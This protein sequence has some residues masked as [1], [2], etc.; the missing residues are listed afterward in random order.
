MCPISAPGGRVVH[1]G[2]TALVSDG[3]EQIQQQLRAA[4]AATVACL[5]PAEHTARALGTVQ[6]SG[7]PLTLVAAGKA[8][9]AMSAGAM[10]VL[11]ARGIAVRAGVVI[12]RAS[13]P[14][15][16]DEA[17]AALPPPL[18]F[19]PSSHPRADARSLA[20]ARTA[21]RLVREAGEGE[22]L[23]LISGGSSALLA[24]PAPGLELS[25]KN[26]VIAALAAG[27]ADIHALNTVRKHLS[28][29][30]GGRLAAAASAPVI[31]LVC[32]DVV[33]DDLS[34][35]GSGPSVPDPTTFAEARAIAR[36][37]T[38]WDALPARARAHLD[39]GVAG[40]LSE[41]PERA[42][43]GDR[44][45]LAAGTGTLVAAARAVCGQRWPALSAHPEALVG[46][47]DAVAERLLGIASE[48][49]QGGAGACALGGG[50]T[51]LAL[52]PEP[53]IGGR[54]QQ[55]ALRLAGALERA[56]QRGQAAGRVSALIAGSD[57][58]D[59]NSPAAGAVVDAFTWRAIRA[60]GRDPEAALRACDAHPA[61]EAVG[62]TVRPGATGVNHAD[63][64]LMVRAP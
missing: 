18:G 9:E 22:V 25:E 24:L 13:Q 48:L 62:A 58:I 17:R 28:A 36:A 4:F 37:H 52:P 53:G 35:V 63:L 33:G 27:G 50:E 46:D 32:S 34:A 47:I 11:D 59:G 5:E 16:G 8:A 23:A 49:G 10:R 64:F 31:T 6:L 45:L 15:E 41:T 56:A 60:R 1:P 3:V 12:G 55:L 43:P 7:R 38:D 40:H 14:G 30:K 2:Y 21:L 61:L 39:A 51:T 19:V 44:A 26:A 42:R 57:G 20:A 29:I 54:A